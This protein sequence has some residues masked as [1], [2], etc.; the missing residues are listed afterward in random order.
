MIEANVAPLPRAFAV[1][2]DLQ[3]AEAA[4]IHVLV[5][6]EEQPN[7]ATHYVGREVH[8]GIRRASKV[9]GG[10]KDYRAPGV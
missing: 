4:A 9:L 3:I 10:L 7:R 2:A 1:D 8:V 5:S 6:E